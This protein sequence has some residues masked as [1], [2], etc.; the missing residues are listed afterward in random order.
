MS[1]AEPIHALGRVT[2]VHR[3]DFHRVVLDNHG[4]HDVLARRCGKMVKKE[5]RCIVGD[6]VA[7]EVSAY[8]P[9]RGRIVWRQ[10]PNNR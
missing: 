2:A 9:R 10:K 1:S 8:D 6:R 7:V 5:I 3:G 4:G